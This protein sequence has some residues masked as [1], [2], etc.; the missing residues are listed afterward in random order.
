MGFNV[1][2]NAELSDGCPVEIWIVI[3]VGF[4]CLILILVI[5]F[6]LC[7]LPKD[8]ETN[9]DEEKKPGA[10][11]ISSPPNPVKNLQDLAF[12]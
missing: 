1:K 12:I 9:S 8:E 4:P 3:M 11:E 5:Y 2:A 7:R 10:Q 6:H